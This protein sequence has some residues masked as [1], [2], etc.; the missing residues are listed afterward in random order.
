MEGDGEAQPGEPSPEEPDSV[1]SATLET[2]VT[3][4]AEEIEPG[5]E[6]GTSDLEITPQEKYYNYEELCSRPFISEDSDIPANLLSLIH[7]FGYDC[8]RR[9]NLQ[10]LDENTLVYI[11]GN[12]LILL[13]VMSK[14]QRYLRSCSGGGIG[15]I[16]VHP[17]KKHLAVAEKGMAPN[18]IIYEYPSLQPYRI[19]RGG[20]TRAYSS[21]D[22]NREGILLASVGS[23][24][25]YMLTIWAWMEERV[26]L[27]CKA[28]S[29]DV[30]QVTFSPDNPGQLTTS[31]AGHIKFWKMT[32]TF[33]GLKLQGLLGRFGKTALT[34]IEGYVE[35]PDGKVVSGSEWGNML[36]WEGGL[37][38]VE[39]C[40]KGGR[41]CHS[42]AIQQFSLDEGEL[43]TIGT[44]GAVRVWD[45]ETIDTADCM[46]DTGF[47]EMEPMNELVIGRNV[48]LSYM[49][50]SSVPDSFIWFAQ[51]SHGGI[52]KL[53]LSFSN[54]VSCAAPDECITLTSS[55]AK[56]CTQD[57]ECLFSFHAGAIQGMDVCS[58]SHLMA[59][60]ALDSTSALDMGLMGFQVAPSG[61]LLAVGFED[62]VVRLLE[63]YYRRNLQPV[64]GQNLSADA[65]MRLKQAFK[66]HNAPVSAIAFDRNGELLATA[67][68]DCTVFLFT[69][70]DRY[71]PIGF[72]RVP[73]PVKNMEWSPPSHEA[74]TLLILCQNGH[75]VEIKAPDLEIQTSSSTYELCG[76]PSRH[77]RF[78]SI[79]SRIKRDAEVARRAVEKEKKKKEREER[80][81]RAKDQGRELTQ[82]EL[83]EEEEEEEPELPPLYTPDPPSPLLCSFYT[84]PGAFWLS[85]SFWALSIHDNQYGL[86]HRVRCSHDSQFVLTA[87]QDGNIFAFSLLP[88]EDLLAALAQRRA[89]V[90]SPRRGIETEKAAQDIEDPNAYSIEMAKQRMELDRLHRVAE[91][92]KAERRMKLA[93]LQKQ[94]KHLLQKNEKLPEHVRLQPVVLNPNPRCPC[95]VR[96]TMELELDKRFREETEQQIAQNIREARKELAW[97]GERYRIGLRKLEERFRD[98]LESDTVTVVAL[99]SQHK[100]STYRLLALA[101]KFHQLKQ[102]GPKGAKVLRKRWR[103]KTSTSKETS[104]APAT[105]ES[106][107]QDVVLQPRVQ[108][109]EGS[110]LAGRQ[111]EKLSKAAEKA[112]QARAKIQKRKDEW[113]ELLASKP[114]ENCEDPQDVLAIQQ[115]MENMGDFKLKTA[116]DFTVPEHLRIDA[117][118]K[119]VQL[120]AL[121]DQIHRRKMKMNV[122]I[123]ALRDSKVRLLS[124]LAEQV[125]KLQ[126][127][128]ASLA[129][130]LRATIPG[131]PTLLPE[132]MP[133]KRMHYTRDMLVRLQ[134]LRAQKGQEKGLL[135]LLSQETEDREDRGT[136][137]APEHT[138][139]IP[140][141]EQSPHIP[142]DH[143]LTQ[144]EEEMR[145]AEEIRLLSMQDN[146]LRKMEQAVKYFDADLKLLR[147]EKLELDV[148]IKMADLQHITLFE[149]LLLLKEFEKRENSLQE[150]L[151]SRMEEDDLVRSKLEECELQLE[152]KRRDIA[153]LQEQEK[154]ITATFLASLGESNKFADF[155][156]KVFK[157]KIKREDS[158]EESEEES[159]WDEDEDG[160]G[161]EC[162]YPL[163]DSVCPP[164][165]DPDLFEVTLQL[166]E[167][168]LDLEEL[169]ADERK[170]L[171]ALRKEHDSLAKKEKIVLN[172]L[173]A[174]EGDLELLNREKQRKLNALDVVVPLRLHQIE[175]VSNG[176]VPGKLDQVLV[177]N[178]APLAGLQERI[179]QLQVEKNHQK[180]RY[181][182]ARQQHIQLIHDCK[183]LEAS[184]Q[185]LE[186]RCEQ[187]M[188]MKFGKL[189]KVTEAKMAMMEVTKQ[190]TERLSRMG[191][192][193]AEKKELED[194]LNYRQRSIGT[195]FQ[196]H[197]HV[198][199][200]EKSR[201]QK[202]VQ[203]QALEIKALREEIDILSLKGAH[204]MPP[205][206]PPLLP[207]PSA[208]PH[209]NSRT[210]HHFPVHG[211]HRSGLPRSHT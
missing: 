97:E 162:S 91:Q 142:E 194:K 52:W 37:I 133:E 206:Q 3:E 48:C 131:V 207:V 126:A 58:T 79:K 67:S 60:T 121:E 63:L 196:E 98:S 203:T 6:E 23:A 93:D 122:R 30:Y 38:K 43:V 19:L 184:I 75:V 178:R 209:V 118:T 158:D 160:E 105:T 18:I 73:G 16:M 47:F 13:D 161:S 164:N 25:D 156:T 128:Q 153:K 109:P 169:L 195:Q 179:R 81:K 145:S 117:K 54:I 138:P 8:G 159:D 202:V 96:I 208:N 199:E 127:V 57:P 149:E 39:I 69:V 56:T 201:L 163:D 41:Q 76:V 166:R 170:S 165:C 144:L 9:A 100:I 5:Q 152:M 130:E 80:L 174:A 104:S 140:E 115:A 55:G 26:V 146:L 175:Y 66:P 31:G 28:F 95:V 112:E 134:T 168:R 176:A 20:T 2:S 125:Q 157:K 139:H 29:Q 151:N 116:E 10:L 88:P 85:M 70:S 106:L 150:R 141:D 108:P 189:D 11:A 94:F 204:V 62:G 188:M 101:C 59:T 173:E 113:A 198:E 61:G 197:G 147:H 33:T 92:R 53:D 148:H 45:F 187:L 78:L 136:A 86:V 49:V 119:R 171:E 72:I 137:N 107:P 71:E 1:R 123:M 102:V 74:N 83:E 65:Q 110:R 90:P 35:L 129:P 124:W 15:A 82:E 17:S 211:G 190:H 84:Q 132:E 111:A 183:D 4:L 7:S 34:D 12:L 177:L 40:R 68:T 172:N 181:R 64:G 24:P 42:G 205:A 14:E 44:D 191:S 22:F 155:L 50:K 143:N 99:Q 210:A 32:S 180:E 51:D 89:K 114:S 21:V 46:D 87:G 167:R 103:S 135:E 36:L 77:F 154:A 185:Q 200:E 193:L 27:R 186:V 192:L 182:Q 120:M